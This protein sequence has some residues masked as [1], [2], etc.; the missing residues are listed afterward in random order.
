MLKYVNKIASEAETHFEWRFLQA[1]YQLSNE[2]HT[3][4]VSGVSATFRTRT[5]REY[6]R[7]ID[8]QDEGF[9]IREILER[10]E[11]NDV[12]WDVGSNIGSYSCF[13]GQEVEKVVAVEPHPQT[14]ARLAENCRLNEV[15]VSILELALGNSSGKTDLHLPNR[16]G[17]QLGVGTFTMQ[18]QKGDQPICSVP[19][20]R[21]DS[22]IEQRNLPEPTVMKIDVEGAEYDVLKGFKTALESCRLIFCELHDRY[23]DQDLVIN[24]LTEAGFSVDILRNRSQEVHII[25]RS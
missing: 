22:I 24:Y 1:K 8:Y 7:A 21:G 18:R 14:A 20:E 10:I 9:L 4:S 6:L 16:F 19:V 3:Q 11:P 25:A 12:F 5:F 15:D 23:V 13:I 2:T 17:D